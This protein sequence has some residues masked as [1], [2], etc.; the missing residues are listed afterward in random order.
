MKN[1]I[2][3]LFFS[4][5]FATPASSQVFIPFSFWQKYVEPVTIVFT[6]TNSSWPVP[7]N[8][9]NSNNSIECIGAGGAGGGAGT[10]TATATP[11][12][13]ASGICNIR[14]TPS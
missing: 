4:C 8:W 2:S 11:G 12:N 10:A 14:F 3:I 9:N 1:F 7:A 5:L 13:G 6:S